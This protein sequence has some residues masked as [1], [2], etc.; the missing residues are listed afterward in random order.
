MSPDRHDRVSELFHAASAHP[1]EKRDAFLTEACGQDA[2]LRADVES[3][4]SYD[5]AAGP[6][7]EKPAA[8]LP[9][10]SDM[11]NRQLGPYTII[12]P[13]GAGGMG[14]VYRARD[15]QA[16]ARRRD[17]DPAVALHRRSRASGAF[18]ARSAPARDAQPSAHRRDLRARRDRWRAP[19]WCSSSSKGPRSPI[20]WRA[21]RC[22][23]E[24]LAIARQ[25]AEALDAAHEKG[26]VHRDLKPA[27]IVLQSVA[28]VLA[29]PRVPRARRSSTSAWPRRWP[30]R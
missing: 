23:S 1:P 11:L 29:F 17:Q 24:A 5:G 27:N 2:A 8:E 3:L 13:L 15:T 20:A 26:I 21:G 10:P 16:R 22:R 6:F 18:R 4:L 14:E 12:A 28:N 25:I 9:A 7:L 30:R 19:R